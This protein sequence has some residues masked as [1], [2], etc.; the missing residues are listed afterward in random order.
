MK[1]VLIVEDHAKSLEMLVE[2]VNNLKMDLTVYTATNV[3]EAYNII[4]ENE[5]DLFILDIILNA[6]DSTDASGMKL[7]N[8]LR[9]MKRYKFT[10]IIFVTSLEDPKLHAYSDVHCYYYIE[11]PYDAQVV[12]NV[13]SD[14]LA[15]PQVK[16]EKKSI[17]F[18]KE[19]ILYKK[20]IS[21]IIYIENTRA[22]QI[23]HYINGEMR[24]SYKPIKSILKD[25]NSNNFIQCSRYAIINK[26]YIDTIDPINRYITLK[27][28][29]E[30]IEI[31]ITLK[32]RF[33]KDILN[34]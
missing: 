21:E 26:D 32:N 12:S 7:A 1:S 17:Y 23:V 10:P 13:I 22:G 5:I 3:S 34:G 6:L 27:V 8:E 19:G 9:E 24:L 29:N 28:E 2:I 4:L 11:K 20:D 31:G 14:A 30:P 16:Q 18:R 25:L 33:M 15:I